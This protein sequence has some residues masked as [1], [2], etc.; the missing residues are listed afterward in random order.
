[1][2][3]EGGKVPS[4]PGLSVWDSLESGELNALAPVVFCFLCFVYLFRIPQF[5]MYVFN[6]P[7]LNEFYFLNRL[8][9]KW[10]LE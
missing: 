9:I 6:I 10:F 3:N 8:N 5:N 2:K 7:Y 1:M 4:S